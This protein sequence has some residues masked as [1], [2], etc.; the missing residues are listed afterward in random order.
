M[1]Q[2]HFKSLEMLRPSILALVTKSIGMPLTTT[3]SKEVG[4]LVLKFISSSLHFVSFSWNLSAVAWLARVSTA[5]WMWETCDILISNVFAFCSG[6]EAGCSGRSTEERFSWV[7]WRHKL[8]GL[9]KLLQWQ[10]CF[11]VLVKFTL[12]FL[13]DGITG[14]SQDFCF[15]LCGFVHL[16][17]S[18]VQMT[19]SCQITFL[20]TSLASVIVAPVK[21]VDRVGLCIKPVYKI[22]CC[23]R[24]HFHLTTIANMLHSTSP[25]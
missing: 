14:P 23:R 18:V 16:F 6:V 11:L 25:T 2:F 15:S 21:L 4:L 13:N 24:Q 10:V 3:G 12:P 20:E 9:E 7:E 19:I 5:A 8:I 1:W 17:S 22:L